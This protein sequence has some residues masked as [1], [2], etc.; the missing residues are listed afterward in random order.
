MKRK[1]YDFLI[2]LPILGKAIENL[3]APVASTFD[4]M[5]KIIQYEKDHPDEK[6]TFFSQ[7]TK[8]KEIFGNSLKER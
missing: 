2:G 8:A 5:E 7:L 4:Y 6:I 1:K 3:L